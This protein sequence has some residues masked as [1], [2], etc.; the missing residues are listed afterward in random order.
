MCIS[1][2]PVNDSWLRLKSLNKYEIFAVCYCFFN[3]FCLFV[4]VC[5]EECR[6]H[7]LWLI[8][9]WHG[10]ITPAPS[11]CIRFGS[12]ISFP[13]G[14]AIQ[15]GYLPHQATGH[16]L[17]N[18]FYPEYQCSNNGYPLYPGYDSDCRSSLRG[19]RRKGYPLLTFIHIY[20]NPIASVIFI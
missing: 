8:W 10:N 7:C 20:H 14:C 4:F 11:M 2:Y 18:P 9:P 17:W 15:P 3:C 5:L 16:N 12:Q 13:S 6:D 19:G 1:A